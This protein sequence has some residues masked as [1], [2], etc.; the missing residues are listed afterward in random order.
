ML[1]QWGLLNADDDD[2]IKKILESDLRCFYQ[3]LE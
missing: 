2:S 3:I 1:Q